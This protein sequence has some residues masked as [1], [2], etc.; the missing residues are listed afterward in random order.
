MEG[1]VVLVSL[2][3]FFAHICSRPS[4]LLITDWVPRQTG[5]GIPIYWVSLFFIGLTS[6]LSWCRNLHLCFCISTSFFSHLDSLCES[7]VLIKG[8]YDLLTIFNIFIFCFLLLQY[9][10]HGLFLLW[11]H[12]SCEGTITENEWSLWAA[13][14]LPV[15]SDGYDK[16]RSLGNHERA[17]AT[18][19]RDAYWCRP[20]HSNSLQRQGK[21]LDT[22]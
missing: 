17:T 15:F 5:R 14:I 21:F 13:E 16:R 6:S 8:L 7:V 10:G 9:R 12:K 3:C 18:V 22:F 11:H 20:M 1:S 4:L 2:C 19:D